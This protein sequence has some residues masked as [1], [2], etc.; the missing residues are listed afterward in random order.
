MFYK[1]NSNT[2]NSNECTKD[3]V[4]LAKDINAL[5]IGETEREADKTAAHATHQRR[6]SCPRCVFPSLTAH[7]VCT[8]AV[9]CQ[10]A[11]PD[12]HMSI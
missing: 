10:P 2:R 11:P 3:A 12:L 5:R 8:A 7:A 1:M 4:Y 6:H 9:E